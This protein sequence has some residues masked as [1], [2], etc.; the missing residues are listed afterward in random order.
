MRPCKARA[1]RD[2]SDQSLGIKLTDEF[3]FHGSFRR[4]NYGDWSACCKA[5][6]LVLLPVLWLK[7]GVGFQKTGRARTSITRDDGNIGSV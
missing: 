1:D 3:P 4:F 2:Y 5:W 7:K 6:Y